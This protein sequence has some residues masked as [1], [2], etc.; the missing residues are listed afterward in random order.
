MSTFITSSFW[1]HTLYIKPYTP[2]NCSLCKL[3]K[4]KV[5]NVY[6]KDG[7]LYASWYADGVRVFDISDTNNKESAPNVKV[8]LYD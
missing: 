8:G 1:A 6:I 4:I 7:L 3:Y 5:N 2:S